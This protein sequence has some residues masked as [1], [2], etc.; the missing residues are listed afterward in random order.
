M[1]L[2]NTALKYALFNALQ[3][4]GKASPGA[5]VGKII[6]EHPQSKEKMKEVSMAASDAVKKVNNQ[7]P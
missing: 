7:N 4:N 5:V 2:K 6:S 3:F 1:D